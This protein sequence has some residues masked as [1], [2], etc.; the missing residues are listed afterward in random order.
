[1]NNILGDNPITQY[2]LIKKDEDMLNDFNSLTKKYSQFQNN[3]T[4]KDPYAEIIN[5][6]DVMIEDL[7]KQLQ[8]SGQDLIDLTLLYNNKIESLRIEHKKELCILRSE[9][10]KKL[11]DCKPHNQENDEL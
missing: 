1:M 3:T 6:K 9:Y 4:K 2:H 11:K 10:M 8:K 7:K 5:S